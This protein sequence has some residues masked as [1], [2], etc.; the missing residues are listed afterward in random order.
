MKTKFV[1]LC[2]K[3]TLRPRQKHFGFFFHFRPALI[4]NPCYNCFMDQTNLRSSLQVSLMLMLLESFTL[5]L[6]SWQAA[7]AVKY[8]L[9][10]N[11]KLMLNKFPK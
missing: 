1:Y 4:P 10:Y 6:H 2:E 5:I 3:P 11:A 9:A 7:K 8:S